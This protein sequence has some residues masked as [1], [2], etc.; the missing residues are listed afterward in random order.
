[1]EFKI[2]FSSLIKKCFIFFCI[3]ISIAVFF[4]N[5]ARGE[6]DS[7]SEVKQ[8]DNVKNLNTADID[9]PPETFS[10]QGVKD[11]QS[12]VK[13]KLKDNKVDLSSVTTSLNRATESLYDNLHEI[14]ETIQTTYEEIV[15]FLCIKAK[16]KAACMDDSAEKLDDIYQDIIK[17]RIKE[18]LYPYWYEEKDRNFSEALHLLNADCVA[19]CTDYAIVSSLIENSDSRY[20]Q[21]YDQIKNKDKRCQID[22][23]SN[24]AQL[25]NLYSFPGECMEEENK[26][27]PVCKDMFKHA[28]VAKNRFL[29]LI[30]LAYG[31][32]ILTK[33]QAR[34][35]CVECASIDNKE[36]SNNL[37]LD[38][39]NI[40]ERNL[41]CR[42][43]K[44]N[45][46][47]AVFSGTSPSTFYNVKKEK[48]G[49]YSISLVLIFY[50]GNDYDGTVPQNKVSEYYMKKAQACM[51]KTSRKMLGPNG[52]KLKINII[53]AS[54]RHNKNI[55]DRQK[56]ID[57]AI[58]S[59]DMRS[60]S[61]H[62]AA[63]IDCVHMTH[64]V[65]H[66]L[67]L[68]DE[69]KETKTGFYVNSKTGEK[70]RIIGNKKEIK[71]LMNDKNYEFKN[72]YDCRVVQK[73]SIMS[74]DYIR[75]WNVYNSRTSESL[76]DPGHFNSILYGDCAIN[77]HFNECSQLAYNDT[78]DHPTCT[79]KK[80]QCKSQNILGRNKQKEIKR[81][82]EQ[83]DI[84]KTSVSNMETNKKTKK[85]PKNPKDRPIDDVILN[86]KKFTMDK[87][88]KISSQIVDD[89]N[90]LMGFF[91]EELSSLKEELQTAKSWPDL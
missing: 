26:N 2:F 53:P 62:Y 77:Q 51:E 84:M 63:D 46:E 70:T 52:E 66:L 87:D 34:A 55:C 73:N 49:S 8:V 18:I 20:H 59:T 82:Q 14:T 76:L 54:V 27:H 13:I 67:G 83:I 35:I 3:F 64:E 61:F 30:N 78:D 11:L 50:P 39:V 68:V 74:Y 28:K 38:A 32:D 21:L 4:S 23:V 79:E 58:G 88:I 57:I 10:F 5:T 9:L 56:I 80:R 86:A 90:E 40:A 25:L 81:I 69:Y 22:I 41:Q 91:K 29:E 17:T 12:P 16:S 15:D 36:S 42:D 72:V 65:L 24:V 6:V 47:K 44:P 33:T 7:T 37:L 60:N 19:N 43:L 75:W 48:D 85:I 71:E 89:I 45:E 31:E 1:M